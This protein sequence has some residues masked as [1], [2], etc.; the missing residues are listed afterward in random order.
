MAKLETKPG[1]LARSYE[2]GIVLLVDTD[3]SVP[4]DFE[5]EVSVVAKFK[6]GPEILPTILR[7]FGK[8]EG[9]ALR[10]LYHRMKQGA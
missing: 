5:V 7:G 9:E 6:R 10:N 1:T 8:T 3:A 2:E 4:V